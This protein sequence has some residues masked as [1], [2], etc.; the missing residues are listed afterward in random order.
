MSEKARGSGEK[1]K[2][3][4]VVLVDWPENYL[5]HILLLGHFSS[6]EVAKAS[7]ADRKSCREGL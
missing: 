5:L 3:F 4:N 6:T 2:Q 7:R 1:L